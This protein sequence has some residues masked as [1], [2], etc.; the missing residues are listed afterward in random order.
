MKLNA[1]TDAVDAGVLVAARRRGEISKITS[2]LGTAVALSA[3]VVG[4]ALLA[5][6][7]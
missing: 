1:L 6:G 4:A 2:A 7:A 5:H 3:V